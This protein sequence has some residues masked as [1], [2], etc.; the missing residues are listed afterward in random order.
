MRWKYFWKVL[1][2]VKDDYPLTRNPSDE[3]SG[4]TDLKR[5]NVVWLA[6][7]NQPADTGCIIEKGALCPQPPHALSPGRRPHISGVPI[8][9]SQPASQLQ[10]V[11]QPSLAQLVS[12][13]FLRNPSNF[14]LFCRL[15]RYLVYRNQ[16]ISLTNFG[17][18]FTRCSE[19]HR[20]VVHT[21]SVPSSLGR[22]QKLL[23][24]CAIIPF[25]SLSVA[26]TTVGNWETEL[27]YVQKE[28]YWIPKYK[29][30]SF[31]TPLFPG[32]V[33][34]FPYLIF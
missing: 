6:G 1:Y 33:L 18:G 23:V 4:A 22:G 34:Y 3:P 5:M 9:F 15:F 11:N 30:S 27:T 12:S 14:N 25:Q 29:T 19:L 24:L 2:H 17:I 26:T 20:H 8:C 21:E 10:P 31:P 13:Y 16:I 28:H 32:L 7:W